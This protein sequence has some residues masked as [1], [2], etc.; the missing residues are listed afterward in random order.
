MIE[1]TISVIAKLAGLTLIPI[2]FAFAWTA[3]QLLRGDRLAFKQAKQHHP[4][5]RDAVLG[6]TMSRPSTRQGAPVNDGIVLRRENGLA[7]WYLNSR[8]SDEQYDR[9]TK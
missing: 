8:M 7:Y 1:V 4:K 3:V 9:L 5:F 2:A 6:K